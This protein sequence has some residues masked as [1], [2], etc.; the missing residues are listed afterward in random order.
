[1][2]VMEKN[3]EASFLN[4]NGQKVIKITFNKKSG[5]HLLVPLQSS[6]DSYTILFTTVLQIVI[7]K[8]IDHTSK[9]I[10]TLIFNFAHTIRICSF[11]GLFKYNFQSPFDPGAKHLFQSQRLGD[12]V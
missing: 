7:K 3:F 5:I 2:R 4:L 11:C 6:A 1:M 10:Q 8:V 12:T 9:T